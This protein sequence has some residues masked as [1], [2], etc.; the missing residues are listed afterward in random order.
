MIKRRAFLGGTM[1]LGASACLPPDQSQLGRLAAKLRIVEAAADGTLG[2]EIYDTATGY[3][4]DLNRNA[5][6]GH[7]S[8]FKL[9][10]AAMIL[11]R[12]STGLD[13]LNRRV[14]WSADDLM[15]Y[16]AFTT[17]RL[18]DGATLGEL[19]EATQKFSD[20]AAANIL[21]R[22][23][24]GPEELTGF[25]RSIGDETSRLNRIEPA[26]NNVP[27]TEL[28][29]TTTPFAMARTVAKI[30]YGDVLPELERE[31]L[32]QWMTDTQTGVRRVRAGLPDDWVAG[33]KTGTSFW[34]GMDSLYVDIG[35]V[36][37]EGRSPITFAAYFR[38][39]ETHSAINPA[40]EQALARVGEVIADFARQDRILSL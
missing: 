31:M 7:C 38:A 13:S 25:W 14:T 18:K 1:A 37:P 2:A 9:S 39:R 8:S 6:F 4:V 36:E 17:E 24:G 21:L 32:R 11:L 30:A 40:S 12:A 29:D 19:A 5:R 20:N 16:S 3:S 26:L 28:R 10:L 34:P 23:A 33:D 22:E 27:A 15:G 35:F